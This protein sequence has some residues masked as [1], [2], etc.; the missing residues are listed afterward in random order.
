VT[1]FIVSLVAGALTVLAP[2]I[3]PLLPVVLGGAAA[4][5]RDRLRP[6]RIVAFLGLSVFAFTFILKASTALIGVPEFFWK[7]FAALIVGALG[8]SLLFPRAWAKIALKI[9]GLHGGG[10]RLLAAGYKKRASWVGDAAVGLGLGPIFTT[11]SPTYFLVLATVL[12]NSFALGALYI[13]AYVL[14]LSLA[15]LAIAWLG[16]SL[17][18]RL[19]A[20]ANPDGLFKR[21]LGVLLILS[22]LAIGTGYDKKIEAAV[23]DS[24]YLDVPALEEKIAGW[25]GKI[26]GDR[27]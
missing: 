12:P 6:L 1:L 17:V 2:C 13:G 10:N 27:R 4:D 14:G 18:A 5:S 15:L 19:G 26:F 8:L 7:G 24:G 23:I 11:C 21:A 22:A 20:A 16:Q 9:P 25:V 3:L